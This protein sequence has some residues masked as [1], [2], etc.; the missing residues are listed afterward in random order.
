MR[1]YFQLQLLRTRRRL[2]D[3]GLPLPLTITLGLATWVA[4]TVYLYDRFAAAPWILIGL[5]M[6]ALWPLSAGKRYD[7]IRQHF[8]LR[9][10]R[11]IRL[12]EHLF[13]GA[14]TLLLLLYFKSWLAA[15]AWLPVLFVLARIRRGGIGP[16][17]LPT[18]FRRRPYECTAGFR[19]YGW[20]LALVYFVAWQGVAAGN[21]NLVRFT[22]VA[23]GLLVMSFYA[24]TPPPELVHQYRAS[25][26]RYLADKLRTA[27]LAYGLF[28]LPVWIALLFRWPGGWALHLLTALLG[29][30]Y[31]VAMIVVRYA[32][33]PHEPAFPRSVAHVAGMLVPPLLLVLLVGWY[34]EACRRLSLLLT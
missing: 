6:G 2:A 15:I 34:R 20:L 33:Y 30:L 9:D 31:V 19:R 26:P 25:A 22:G 32:S 10:A 14:P 3:F 8:S 11:L 12:T 7:G 17:V 29:G 28:A 21:V 18:P 23:C 27:T 16:F 24:T 5:T 1:Y 4:G 13:A